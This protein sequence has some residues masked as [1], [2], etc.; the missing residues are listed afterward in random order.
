MPWITPSG[1]MRKRPRTSTPATSFI[2]AVGA[3]DR[4]AAIGRHREGN[5]AFDHL[6]QLDV[7]PHLVDE[8]TVDADGNHF[9]PESLK[10]R[11]FIGDR[12]YLGRSDECKKSPG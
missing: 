7:V 6:R 5:A 10:F 1:S 4:A 9:G 11:V 8:L 3:T 12:R 2:D